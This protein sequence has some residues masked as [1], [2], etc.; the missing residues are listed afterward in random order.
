MYDETTV[1]TTIY[2]SKLIECTDLDWKRV[3][4]PLDVEVP[5]AQ[6]T[7]SQFRQVPGGMVGFPDEARRA[8]LRFGRLRTPLRVVVEMTRWTDRSVEIGIRPPRHLPSG[9]P[10]TGT[11]GPPTPC[12]TG[13]PHAD[14]A[15]RRR[16]GRS[17]A[18]PAVRL[19]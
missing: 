2:A 8:T 5:G 4:F 18:A 6:L 7:I 17:G 1:P 13:W 3:Q 12:W 11:S 9:C 19:S 10:A 15:R 14:P 16:P